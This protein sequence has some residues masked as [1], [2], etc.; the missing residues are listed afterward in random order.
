MQFTAARSE[1]VEELK[2]ELTQ[3]SVLVAARHRNEMSALKAGYNEAIDKLKAEMLQLIDERASAVEAVKRDYEAELLA[4]KQAAHREREALRDELARHPTRTFTPSSC[5]CCRRSSSCS[6]SREHASP[7]SQAKREHTD[8]K[9]QEDLLSTQLEQFEKAVGELRE[10]T[11]EGFGEQQQQA[12]A[13]LPALEER[14]QRNAA[15][16]ERSAQEPPIA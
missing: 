4:L 14:F 9:R 10:R 3:Q 16:Q 11:L 7:A 5:A 13:I 2:Q 15:V 1:E 12:E 6:S 8:A